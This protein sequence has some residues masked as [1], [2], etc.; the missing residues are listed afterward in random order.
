LFEL[1]A[2]V[3]LLLKQKETPLLEHSERKDFIHG[4]AYLADIYNH[5]NVINLSVQGPELTIMDATEKL[6]AFLAKLSI[7]K[8]TVEVKH[9]C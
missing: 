1:R 2:E 3:P 8:K 5:M 7:W 6:Q 9:P 4:Q